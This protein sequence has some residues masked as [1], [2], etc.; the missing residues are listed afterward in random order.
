MGPRGPIPGGM[1]GPCEMAQGPG[2]GPG[3]GPGPG[4]RPLPPNLQGPMTDLEGIN[5]PND[6]PPSN[7]E[8]GDHRHGDF[9]GGV[10]PMNP[11]NIW[12]QVIFS[13]KFYL[14]P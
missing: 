3:P 4:P 7:R 9:P 11:M 8:M 10:N 12:N 14:I 6:L 5:E 13:S 1:S 2:S